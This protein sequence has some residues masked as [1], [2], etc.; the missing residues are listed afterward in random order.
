MKE[1]RVCAEC[2]SGRRAKRLSHAQGLRS[3]GSL[4]IDGGWTMHYNAKMRGAIMCVVLL[5]AIAGTVV[6]AV[7]N[8]RCPS[9]GSECRP[10]F[11]DERGVQAGRRVAPVKCWLRLPVGG[12]I[13]PL[14]TFGVN[15][16]MSAGVLLML[17]GTLSYVAP[18][19]VHWSAAKSVDQVGARAESF[20]YSR[21]SVIVCAFGMSLVLLGAFLQFV[22]ICAQ[23]DGCDDDMVNHVGVDTDSKMIGVHHDKESII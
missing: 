16:V 6:V 17:I 2:W 11:F 1:W 9:A 13:I 15:V 23:E 19:R 14:S 8:S 12:V 21:C 4:W 22:L 5:C 10:D 7:S 18:R 3:I 20:S